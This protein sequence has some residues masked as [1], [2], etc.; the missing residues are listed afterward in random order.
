[1]KRRLEAYMSLEAAFIIPLAFYIFIIIVYFTFF[2]FNHKIVYD[3]CYISALRG[4]QLYICSD[5]DIKAYVENSLSQ[6]LE[7][8]VYQYQIEYDVSINP[9]F[10]NISSS[11]YITNLLHSIGLYDETTLISSSIV[12][13]RRTNPVQ[14]I[15]R[16]SDL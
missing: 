9:I 16:L 15:R 14:Y 10:I 3:S 5:S 6:L 4:N 2:L 8:Q 12:E 13:Y 7:E 11:S 1:M